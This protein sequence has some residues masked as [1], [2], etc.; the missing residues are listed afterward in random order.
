MYTVDIWVDGEY[1]VTCYDVL[2]MEDPKIGE[3]ILVD[4]MVRGL[5]APKPVILEVKH[6]KDKLMVCEFIEYFQE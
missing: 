6:K 4:F 1:Q 5:L 3:R 2:F